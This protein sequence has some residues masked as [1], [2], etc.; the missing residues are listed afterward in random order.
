MELIATFLIPAKRYSIYSGT[1]VATGSFSSYPDDRLIN[2]DHWWNDTRLW[3]QKYK[4]ENHIPVPLFH[5]KFQ[6][7]H[8]GVEP[9]TSTLKIRWIMV[10]VSTLSFGREVKLWFPCRRFKACERFL[11]ATWKS[12]ILRLNLQPISRPHSFTFGC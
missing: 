9:E 5:H 4:E 3:K 8:H 7:N 12:D 6:T 11:N 10:W 1:I 2:T